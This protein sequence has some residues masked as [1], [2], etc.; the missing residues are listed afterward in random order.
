[1]AGP[2]RVHADALLGRARRY[3]WG[4]L[5]PASTLLAVFAT[6]VIASRRLGPAEFGRF[7]VASALVAILAVVAALGVPTTIVTLLGA[8]RDDARVPSARGQ[9]PDG[10]AVSGWRAAALA[11]VWCAAFAVVIAVVISEALL[12]D[13]VERWIPRGTGLAIGLASLGT[14]LLETSLA[15][16][17]RVREFRAYFTR[18]VGGA[19]TRLG[20]V[21][22]GV[23][24]FAP[25]ARAAI[26]GY[27]VAA[28]C[29]GALLAAPSTRLALHAARHER[30]ALRRLVA[31]LFERS[32]PVLGSTIVVVAIG[33]LDTII[34]AG[35]M[36]ASDV[37]VYAAA[38]RL[39]IVPSTL[40]GGIASLALPLAVSAWRDGRVGEF[41]TTV[42]RGGTLLGVVVVGVLALGAELI[43]RVVY[44]GAFAAAGP[45]FMVLAL[46]YLASF[47]G[48][49]MSQV[50]F[51]AGRTRTL[52][53]VQTLQ[54]ATTLVGLGLLLGR[55]GPF[56]IAVLRAVVNVAGTIAIM[57]VA[58]RLGRR[59]PMLAT[60][61]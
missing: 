61:E 41:N 58:M 44:G 20:G 12:G 34:V 19:I 50:L 14:A 26:W 1:M 43:V 23:F 25:T 5:A 53:V 54:L 24:A 7:A 10:T 31:S 33:W 15:E 42:L 6:N 8:Q 18:M 49:P 52:L 45:V 59:E 46:G 38:V 16:S 17:Q 30:P 36:A 56:E 4:V 39:T 2:L 60:Q 3:G 21:A 22:V 9:L 37:G 40:I 35:R 48:N 51:A 13:D 27:A 28:L 57:T 55:T 47:P 32:A 29:W 11:T